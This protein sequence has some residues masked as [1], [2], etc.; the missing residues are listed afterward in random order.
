MIRELNIENA[1]GSTW[2]AG[3]SR[4]VQVNLL[5]FVS[6]DTVYKAYTAYKQTEKHA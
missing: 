5:H 2:G 3:F 6:P 1:H 4:G